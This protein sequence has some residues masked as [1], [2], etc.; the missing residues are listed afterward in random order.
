M[1]FGRTRVELKVGVFVF[2]G[3]IILAIFVWRIGNLNKG[4]SGYSANFLFKFVNGVRV[5]APIRFA[6][7]DIGEVKV[8]KFIPSDGEQ[9][10]QVKITGWLRK[11]V[12]IP[13]DSS[14][15]INTL[16]LLGEKYVEIMPGKD[17]SKILAEN[18]TLIGTD[19]IPMQE[20]GEIAKRIAD[21]L[22]DTL[23]DLDQTIVRINNKEGTVGKL[24]YDD[25]IYKN[26]D[27]F[28]LDL[29]EHPWKLLFKP[30]EKPVKK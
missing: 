29:K 27:A 19:P 14:V 5:G 12:S 3:G 20:V 25:T 17:Y 26:I 7:V 2:I 30:K 4:V 1:I 11:D 16:G 15:W 23:N 21:R 8:M 22:Q 18:D 9:K 6:G 10:T 13:G 24:L 28:V